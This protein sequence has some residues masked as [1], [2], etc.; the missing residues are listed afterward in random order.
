M[1]K[2]KKLDNE[3]KSFWDLILCLS[4]LVL[5]ILI[6]IIV[7]P[8]GLNNSSEE[9]SEEGDIINYIKENNIAV[10][11]DSKCSACQKQLKEFKP[12]EVEAITERVFVFCDLTQDMGCIGI[13]Y[14]PTWKKNGEIV[15]VG[16]LPLDD[17]NSLI[18]LEGG[19]KNEN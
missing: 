12:F 14:V 18:E 16:F 10:Y 3:K 8:K 15:F 13:E 17:I 6:L 7:N 1:K 9:I 5:I 19:L 4:F 11:G 2:N